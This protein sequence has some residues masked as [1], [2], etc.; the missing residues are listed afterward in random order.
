MQSLSGELFNLLCC[1]VKKSLYTSLVAHQVGAYPGF[2]S[3]KRPGV[4]LL[5]PPL[6]NRINQGSV[7]FADVEIS[8]AK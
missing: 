1:G 8:L 7:S 3:M 5:P 2:R 4:F 6:N